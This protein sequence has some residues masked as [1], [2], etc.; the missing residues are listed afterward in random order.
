MEFERP[1]ICPQD[2]HRGTTSDELELSTW[3]VEGRS[4]EGAV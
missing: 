3:R 2:S 4:G 1:P